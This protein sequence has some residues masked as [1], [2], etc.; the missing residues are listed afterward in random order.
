MSEQAVAQTTN[1]AETKAVETTA[2]ETK[3][4]ETKAPETK[5]VETKATETPAA[6]MISESEVKTESKKEEPAA[7]APEAKPVV[8]EK[9]DLKLPQDSKLSADVVAKIEA[10]AK[11]KG[12]TQERAQEAVD[13][14]DAWEAQRAQD[15]SQQIQHLN[16]KVWKEELAI[17]P[18]Y[19]G[20]KFEESGHFAHKAAE[21]YGGKEFADQLK[22]MKLNHQPMLF[23]FL[24]NVGRSMESDKAVNLNKQTGSSLPKE[25]QMYPDMYKNKE[26]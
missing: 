2:V 21:R 19:G 1:S 9:Y 26:K 4:V 12:W 25:Q 23:K 6:S 13:E 17:D 18:E 11:A 16:D 15:Q 8:P 20:Q 14:R 10:N 5:T 22:S 3:T 24:V 7:K